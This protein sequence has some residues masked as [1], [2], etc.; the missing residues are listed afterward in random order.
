MS[1]TLNQIVDIAATNTEFSPGMTSNELYY[2]NQTEERLTDVIA[3]VADAVLDKAEATHTHEGYAAADHS[4]DGYAASSHT[5]TPASIGAAASEHS[6]SGYAASSHGHSYNDLS[7]KPTIPA[8]YTHPASHPASMITGLAEVAT[9]GSYD[10]LTDKPTIPAAYSHP[11]SHPASMITGLA[12]VA[13]SGSYDDLSNKPTI[14]TVPASLPANGGNADTVD[15][16]HASDFATA[17]HTHT[18]FAA[19]EH[20]HTGY[21]ASEHT[22]TGF[23]ASDHTHTPVSIGAA[24]ASHASSTTTYGVSTASN[25]G[26]AKASGTTPKAPGEAAVGSETAAFARGDHVHPIQMIQ[27]G[28][29][30][31]GTGA[32]Y[33]ATV[34]GITAL[35]AGVAFIMIPHVVSTVVNPTLN[36]NGLGAKNLR[37]RVSNSTVTT[38]TGSAA[39]W[40][41]ANKPIRVIYD[42]SFWIADFDRPNATDIYGT[43]AIANGGTGA[44]TAAA[45]LTALGAFP[46][47]GGDISGD[48]NVN[49]VI[50]CNG[51]QAF[52]YAA[53]TN[54]Q[55]IGTNNATGGTTIA[56]GSEATVALNGALTKTPTV[57]PK[58]SNA[59]YCG[60]ANF[61]WKGIYSNAAVNVSSDERLKRDIKP[62]AG[63]PLAKFIEALNVVSYNYTED[64]ADAK[65]RI[66]L[67]A[68]DVQRA[69]AE[70]AKFFVDEDENGMLGLTPADLVFPL[71]AAVQALSKRVAELE[72]K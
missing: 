31:A 69:D 15:N 61:R 1:L 11:A 63:D 18:G 21:A 35:T 6:H 41:G 68:Q 33:T 29:T 16:K 27:K 13:T 66:G 25:Y 55:T 37:R 62:L 59:Y 71:I 72:A 22:H 40:L 44:T 45:A 67:I 70:I 57:I 64:A 39:N 2:A 49:G 5:H 17:D 56:C 32:A 38:T 60:N 53:S 4:H 43:V 8:A 58:T 20:T 19:S 23:A 51:Q 30:T 48:T 10:D 7:D 3:A 65:S 52:Y 36:V 42:G 54:S 46:A 47:A 12:D 14:P 50:R 26:H 24:P 34:D 28:V 9:T